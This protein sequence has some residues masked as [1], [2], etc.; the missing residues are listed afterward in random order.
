MVLAVG[1]IGGDDAPSAH[2]GAHEHAGLVP[3][4][5]PRVAV[6]LGSGAEQVK[7]RPDEEPAR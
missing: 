1:R 7:G 6:D 2:P 4:A 3:H 5:V